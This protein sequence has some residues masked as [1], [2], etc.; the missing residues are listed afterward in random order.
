MK[1]KRF[2]IT[3]LAL[4]AGM[5]AF[6]QETEYVQLNWF[7]G[8]GG[9]VNIGWNGNK[10]ETRENSHIGAGYAV[11]VYIGKWVNQIAG[12]RVGW[13]G[14]TVSDQYVDFGKKK[15]MY[16][17]GDVLIRAHQNVIPYLHAG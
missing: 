3:M 10:F 4:A 12:L 9:G 2:F 14:L 15:L 7:A 8:V 11:D 13:Q 5:T 1:I 17:H 6:A 16:L